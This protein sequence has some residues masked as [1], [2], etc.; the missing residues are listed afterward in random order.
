MTPNIQ[1]P[2]A[3]VQI[4]DPVTV[5]STT[6]ATTSTAM[7]GISAIGGARP[8]TDP[9]SHASTPQAPPHLTRSHNNLTS[10]GYPDK[11]HPGYLTKEEL[12]FL[13][14]MTAE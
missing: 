3:E 11:G 2:R 7:A 14:E 4:L 9:L 13:R 6:T 12:D 8:R 10:K 5:P 1:S